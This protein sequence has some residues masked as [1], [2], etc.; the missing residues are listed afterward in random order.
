MLSSPVEGGH[1][2]TVEVAGNLPK[3]RIGSCCMVRRLWSE[4]KRIK[5]SE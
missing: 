1:G 3:K 4:N 5:K 2:F